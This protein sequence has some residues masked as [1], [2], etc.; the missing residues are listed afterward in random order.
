MSSLPCIVLVGRPNVGK[1]TLFNRLIRSNRAITHD[2]P[3]VTRDRMEGVVRR[4]GHPDF[5][6]VD[7]APKA[8][9]VSSPTSCAR[10]RRP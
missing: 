3:G 10:P 8:S 1:S 4:K 2:R 9:A 7:K 6:I 5:G